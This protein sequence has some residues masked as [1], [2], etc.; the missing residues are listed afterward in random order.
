VATGAFEV[1]VDFSGV[2]FFC[3][4]FKTAESMFAK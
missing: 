4:L 2:E 1:E 3:V